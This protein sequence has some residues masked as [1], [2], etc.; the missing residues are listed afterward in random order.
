MAYTLPLAAATPSS[1]R[2][3]DSAAFPV[4]VP[5]SACAGDAPL[6]NGASSIAATSSAIS[7]TGYPLPRV[8]M[9]HLLF[10]ATG[11]LPC[12]PVGA[13][14]GPLVSEIDGGARPHGRTSRKRAI[15]V[16]IFRPG[17]A[18]WHP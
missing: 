13:G 2:P 18:T 10:G 16:V 4:H 15:A 17:T 12:H 7:H 1:A 14:A 8:R 6:E 3:V 9:A 5:P 11:L